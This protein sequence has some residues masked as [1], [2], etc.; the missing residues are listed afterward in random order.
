M[1]NRKLSD[2]VLKVLKEAQGNTTDIYNTIYKDYMQTSDE[3]WEV[4]RIVIDYPETVGSVDDAPSLI[5]EEKHKTIATT[6]RRLLRE[7][8]RVL[9]GA[10][11][12]PDTFYQKLYRIV[13]NSELF[14]DDIATHTVLLELLADDVPLLPYYYLTDLLQM[15]DSVFRDTIAQITPQLQKA[16]HI[17]N[18]HF[19]SKTEEVSQLWETSMEIEP[20]EA[21]IVFWTVVL[22]I[23]RQA[24]EEKKGANN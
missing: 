9:V 2:K 16:V 11:M 21:K 22:D 23:I 10:N 12:E 5:D 17:L 1:H 18:R 19:G 7:T 3:P 14:P 8:V 6:Y 4:L 15:P 24:Y 20:K 13:F